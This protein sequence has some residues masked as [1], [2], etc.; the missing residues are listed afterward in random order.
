VD[1]YDK[2]GFNN[3]ANS[4][5]HKTPT[6]KSVEK[7][8]D[9]LGC[10]SHDTPDYSMIEIAEKLNMSKGSVHRI[11]LTAQ[12]KGFIE[13]NPST[14][15]YQLGIKLFEL[16]SVVMLRTNLSKESLPVL[17]NIS[18]ET[19]ET[20]YVN[21][22]ENDDALC[23]QR[24][25]GHNYLR[26]LFLEMGKKMPL[27]I[28]AG[29][30]ILLAYM[31]DQDI[32]DW[33]ARKHELVKWTEHTVT[34]KNLIW[35]DIKKIR[36]RGYAESIEDVT[37]GVTSIGAPIRNSEGKVI[38]AVSIGG[39]SINFSDDKRDNLIKIVK[40]AGLQISKRMGYITSY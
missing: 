22:K 27:Y 9:L 21:I 3:K 11:L 32:E 26:V 4:K 33:F 29:P 40:N 2:N 24:V 30:K 6:L 1:N 12:K 5:S 28:G 39:A 15:R 34:D 37:S 13:K 23:I 10:F 25:E 19:G 8:F 36:D 16:G 31:Q 35:Q 18:S 20:S 17:R 14:K 7:A 38:A